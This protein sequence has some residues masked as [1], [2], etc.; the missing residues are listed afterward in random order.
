MR[1]MAVDIRVNDFNPR[2]PRGERHN[3]INNKQ[4]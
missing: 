4:G 2:P 3:Y 1:G